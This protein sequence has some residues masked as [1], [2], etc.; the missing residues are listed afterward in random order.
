MTR[1]DR[2]TH[3]VPAWTRRRMLALLAGTAAVAVALIVGLVLA[4]FTV[5]RPHHAG[6][7]GGT[8]APGMITDGV[9]V[10]PGQGGPTPSPSSESGLLVQAQQD[11]LAAKAMPRVDES[12]AEPGPVSTRDAGPPLVLP[13]ATT[14]GPAQVPSGFPHSLEG[15]MA[16]LAAIDQTALQSGSLTG[17]R[18]VLAAWAQ[19]GGPTGS[20]WSGITALSQ[21]LD[22]A[23]LSGG[24]SPQLS[25]VLTPLMGQVKASLGA[26]WVI[27]CVDF[28]LDATLSSTARAGVADCQRMAWVPDRTPGGAVGGR[29]MIA[30]GSEPAE[31]PSV[32]PDTD[33]AYAVGYRDLAHA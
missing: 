25:L 11:S 19:P 13:R 3:R 12:A 17:A 22:S 9:S 26:D 32:W 10:P 24:G 2:T 15:A 7:G 21:L 28:E 1:R 14:T 31:A 20:S 4:V 33:T 16:Q 6:S 23:G 29:W 27:P 30:P 5:L 8:A 18:T